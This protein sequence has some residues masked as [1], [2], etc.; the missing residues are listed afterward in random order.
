MF[1]TI[2]IIV[3]GYFLVRSRGKIRR[4]IKLI[5]QMILRLIRETIMFVFILLGSI[6]LWLRPG[7]SARQM[8]AFYRDAFSRRLSRNRRRR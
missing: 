5:A 1:E 3:G 7:Q 4:A 2:V 8:G 6:P